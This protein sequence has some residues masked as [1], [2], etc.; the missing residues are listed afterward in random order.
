VCAK[1]TAL[2]ELVLLR[3]TLQQQPFQKC[4]HA[5]VE[6]FVMLS[7][8]WILPIIAANTADGGCTA[9]YCLYSTDV[10]APAIALYVV[11]YVCKLVV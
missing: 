1:D 5:P 10:I 8:L 6:E 11:E 9:Y 4:H 3:A 7:W 2:R